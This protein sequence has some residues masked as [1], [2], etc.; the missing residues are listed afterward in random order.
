M[1]RRRNTAMKGKVV[2]FLLFV[3]VGFSYAFEKWKPPRDF[4][5]AKVLRV[6]DGDTIVISIKKTTFNN[7]KTLKNLK[8]TVRLIGIDTPESKPN[9]R[10]KLQSRETDKDIKTIIKLGK[11]AKLFTE[12][13]LSAGKRK[14]KNVYLE[15]DVQPQ[16]RYGRLLAYV[17]LPDGRMLN[18]EIVC[19]GYAYPLTIPPNIK[20][21]KEFLKCFRYAR[22]NR[23][24]LW[25]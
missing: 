18:R 25:R 2:F 17:W 15:F 11:K 3:L 10:A 8:F 22:E 16:D 1:K 24:G 9:R 7:R 20:Y 14:Y 23:L 12:S 19:N 4:V 6:V 5:K 21:E 13:L